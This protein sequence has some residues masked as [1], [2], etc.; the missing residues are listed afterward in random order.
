MASKQ[1]YIIHRGWEDTEPKENREEEPLLDMADGVACRVL[2]IVKGCCLSAG[3]P[4][5]LQA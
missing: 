1:D 4:Q 5:L 3:C 2:G